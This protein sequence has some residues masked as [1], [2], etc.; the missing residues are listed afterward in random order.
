MPTSGGVARDGWYAIGLGKKKL[1]RDGVAGTA[2]VVHFKEMDEASNVG[3]AQ[4]D[5]KLQI[6]VPGQEPYE[7]QGLFR[8]PAK[9][10]GTVGQGDVL[11][12]KVHP[13]NPKKAAIDWELW[14]PDKSTG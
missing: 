11:P 6:T 3:N 2:T 7:L 4:H 13:T 14:T 12:V 5:F 8:I 10:V 1:L 9:L